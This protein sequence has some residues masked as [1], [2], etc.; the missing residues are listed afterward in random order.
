MEQFYL[1]IVVRELFWHVTGGVGVQ[2]A[3]V[4]DG[5]VV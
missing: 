5:V 3:L 1:S 2:K 4:T